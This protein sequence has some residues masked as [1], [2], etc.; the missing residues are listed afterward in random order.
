MRDEHRERV[1]AELA[2]LTRGP[3]G[4]RWAREAVKRDPLSEEAACRLMTLLAESGDRAAAMNEYVRL[5][6][7][8]ERELS[9]APSRETRRL[10]AEI[11]AGAS[12]APVAAPLPPALAPRGGALAGRADELERLLAATGA[13]APGPRASEAGGASARSCSPASRAS[14]RRACSRRPAAPRTRAVPSV[15]YGRCYEEPVAPYEPFAEAL[16][17]DTLKR[18]LSDADGERWRLFEAIGARLEGT[19]LLLD[20]LHWADA[21]TLRLLAHVLRRPKP[22]RVL[23]AYRDTEIG[24]T[25]PLAAVLADLRRDGLVE[26]LPLRGLTAGEV[27]AMGG[28][29]EI[30]AETGGNPFFV[31]EVLAASRAD[32]RRRQG[33]DRPAALAARR[34]R[35]TRSCAWPRSR[36][37]SSTWTCWRRCSTAST[38]S[39]RSSRRARRRWSARSAPAATCSPTRSSA[40]RSTTS[41]A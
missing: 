1:A 31:E 39:P 33:R 29:E 22:P 26:R 19:V 8:L 28:T 18:L 25:H 37:A 41:S 24:R 21:G 40:R 32:P 9:I 27:Q 5:E 10:L 30:A 35:R 23:G 38:C 3:D 6:D 20:D 2:T 17:A 7:R 15:L 14:A 11:R 13:P 4:L 16:G 34:R 12:A 36:A